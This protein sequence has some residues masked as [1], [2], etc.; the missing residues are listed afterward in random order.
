MRALFLPLM[1]LHTRVWAQ[2][3]D[4]PAPPSNGSEVMPTLGQGSELFTS[5]LGVVVVVSVIIGIAWLLR[6]GR[7]MGG[8]VAGVSLV[9]QLPLGVKEKLIVVQVGDKKLLLGCTSETI[10][11]LHSWESSADSET[12]P[13]LADTPFASVLGKLRGDTSRGAS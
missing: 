13:P 9:G 1:L 12:A 10:N 7:A 5:G 6:R 2:Q 3:G 8:K 11:R 4:R